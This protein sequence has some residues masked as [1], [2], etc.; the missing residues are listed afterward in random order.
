MDYCHPCRRHLN[1]ALACA[2]CGTPAQELR[3]QAPHPYGAP[4][5]PGP[6][7]SYGTPSGTPAPSASAVPDRDLPDRD[8]PDLAVPPSTSTSWT[9]SRRRAV[10]PEAG[11]PPGRGR[12]GR[13]GE[14][15]AG[16]V[17]FSSARSGWCSPPG[18]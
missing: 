17:R 15:V 6:Y 11:V 3:Q 9:S 12:A 10:L 14:G 13:G 2:G 18:R 8:V 7:G 1:G 4:A 16:A 5:A